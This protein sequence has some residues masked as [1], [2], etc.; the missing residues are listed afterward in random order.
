MSG[1]KQE[2]VADIVAEIRAKN[3]E[4]PYP[5]EYG[6][7]VVADEMRTLADRI[8]AANQRDIEKI[9]RLGVRVS[10]YEA[11]NAERLQL[12]RENARL[13]A[14]AQRDIDTVSDYYGRLVRE[15][16]AENNRLRAA[17]R[18]VLDVDMSH[19]INI[20][21]RCHEAVREARRIYGA[22]DEPNARLISAAPELYEALRLCV[23]ELCE[24]CRQCTARPC[25]ND[26]ETVRKARA[27]LEK[28]GGAE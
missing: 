13:F 16:R 24:T 28:A 8:E 15:L 21:P 19:C 10:D 9:N 5:A 2:T 6:G 25:V 14:E 27:A 20:L 17:L 23:A 3:P 18:T 11:V 26:C 22:A 12:R 7:G 1:K 4:R